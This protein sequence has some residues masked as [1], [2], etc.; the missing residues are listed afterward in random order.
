MLTFQ[1]VNRLTF[2]EKKLLI[3]KN[4]LAFWN[5]HSSPSSW[6]W[7][8]VLWDIDTI[9]QRFLCLDVA[10]VRNQPLKSVEKVRMLNFSKKSRIQFFQVYTYDVKVSDRSAHTYIYNNIYTVT[11]LRLFETGDVSFV[12]RRVLSNANK[13]VS[14]VNKW[15]QSY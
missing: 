14:H 15:V 8:P 5:L 13:N 10:V 12:L 11:C 3:P 2:G 6:D 4:G 7:S 9:R 1:K